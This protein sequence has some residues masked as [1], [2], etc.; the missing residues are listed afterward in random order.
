[1]AYN[2]PAGVT[3]MLTTGAQ[4]FMRRRTRRAS[5]TRY[6]DLV[7]GAY[8]ELEKRPGVMG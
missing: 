4:T 3:R 5:R 7:E 2:V 6:F 1:M 8:R